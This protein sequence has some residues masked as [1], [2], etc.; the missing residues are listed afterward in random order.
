MPGRR[1]ILNSIAAACGLLFLVVVPSQADPPLSP[2]EMFRLMQGSE[3]SYHIGPPPDGSGPATYAESLWPPRA[4][5]DGEPEELELARTRIRAGEYAD[6]RETLI[7]GLVRR[8]RNDALL[9][10]LRLEADRLGVRVEDPRFV[11]LAAVGRDG[12]V[13]AVYF[14]P[15]CAGAQ[16]MTYAV[17]KAVWLGEADYRRRRGRVEQWHWSSVEERDCLDSLVGA[18]RTEQAKDGASPEPQLER[19]SRIVVDEMLD[20][21]VL[22]EIATRMVPGA[23]VGVGPIERASL[24]EFVTRHVV[25]PAE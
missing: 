1:R 19:L 12:E 24:R 16:W 10:L 8:P 13:V 5:A 11:P 2:S 15:S 20:D 21:F 23:T 3:V 6:A 25:L 22:W 9:G 17:C 14:D 4:P 7:D 18:Y